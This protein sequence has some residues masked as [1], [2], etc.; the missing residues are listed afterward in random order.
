MTKIPFWVEYPFKLKNT[1]IYSKK[2]KKGI[3]RFAHHVKEQQK[4]TIAPDK[5]PWLVSS[6]I[7]QGWPLLLSL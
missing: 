4:N 3:D 6:L 2:K 5:A 7:A 1:A